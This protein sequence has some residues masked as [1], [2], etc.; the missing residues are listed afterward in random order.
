MR[1][2]SAIYHCVTLPASILC[3]VS[4]ASSST[5]M[6]TSVWVISILVLVSQSLMVTS[7][8]WCCLRMHDG[9]ARD[10]MVK[11]GWPV[12]AEDYMQWVIEAHFSDGMPAW[13]KV[14]IRHV[15]CMA[16]ESNH[17]Y[18]FAFCT[19]VVLPVFSWISNLARPCILFK[20]LRV[21]RHW[22]K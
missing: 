3:V 4:R 6:I 16:F 11:D 5:P 8:N 14:F 7:I 13:D 19:L 2:W 18:S 1:V 17:C 20:H 21:V 22:Y 12:I 9:W 15:I 10:Y